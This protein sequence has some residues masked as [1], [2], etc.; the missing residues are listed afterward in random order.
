MSTLKTILK[1]SAAD[2]MVSTWRHDRS[3][4]GLW[5]WV[6]EVLG[7]RVVDINAEVPVFTKKD[8]IPV[9]RQWTVQLWILLHALIPLGL[10]H[11][12][13]T[14]T[15]KNLNLIATF[16][17]YSAAFKLN[18]IHEIQIIC[19]LGQFYGFL[20]GDKHPRDDIPD[21]GVGKII[22][23]LVSMSTSR[24]MMAMF[25]AYRPSEP[26]V[27][28]EWRWLPLEIGLYSITIDFWF[29]WYHRMMHS[30][31]PLWR[32]HR[33]HHLTKHPNPMLSGY[34][35]HEQ[36]FMDIAGIPLFSYT[37]LKLLGLPMGFYECWIAPN[38]LSLRSFLGIVAS[39]SM[40]VR[41]L[42]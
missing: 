10:H 3:Q 23:G 2:S 13:T 8:K 25:L 32:F 33:R 24:T 42:P 16:A 29:Y 34:A 4:W 22:W 12:Y 5:H 20:D 18:V 17:L 26:P 27:S 31:G 11:A 1:R 15:G 39:E 19:R 38:I 14:Y 6:I 9:I 30:V 35:D 37:T 40:A 41:L 21:V 7:L 28:L 36:E